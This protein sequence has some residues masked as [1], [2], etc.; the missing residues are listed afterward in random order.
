MGHFLKGMGLVTVMALLYIHLQMNIYALAYQGKKKESRIEKLAEH[1]AGV[2]NDILRLQ[3]SD[4]IGREFLA[5]E[6]SGYRFASRRN[7]VEVESAATTNVL[8]D[9]IERGQGLVGRVMTLAFASR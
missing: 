1:N 6:N 9:G 2:R 8:A 7:V 4:N 3:S 5:R